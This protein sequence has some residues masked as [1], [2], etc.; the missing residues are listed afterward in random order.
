MLIAQITDSHF[1]RR[2]TRVFG[3]VDSCSALEHAVD[4]LNALPLRP[5]AVFHS[6]DVANDGEAEDYAE[7]AEILTRLEMPLYAVP[8]NH[9]RRDLMRAALAGHDW[10]PDAGNIHFTADIG[11]IRLV[12]L[13]SL[14]EGKSNGHLND[15][16]LEFLDEAL[17]GAGARPALVF[18]HHPPFVSGVTFMDGSRLDN[19]DDLAAVLRRHDNAALVAAGHIHRMI[20][21]EVGGVPAVISPGVAHQVVLGL[22]PESP[23]S[24]ICEP[25]ACLLHYWMQETGFVTH[26]SFIG[27]Y[28]PDAPFSSRHATI[29]KKW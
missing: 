8:G 12:G 19:A 21:N 13:D 16:E 22:H 14:V 2:G 10:M 1:L 23:T 4:H 9:D 26:L 11:D 20:I 25:P 6:G 7:L 5:D 17:A 27:E 24:W 18:F 29:G 3:A 15:G 28:K